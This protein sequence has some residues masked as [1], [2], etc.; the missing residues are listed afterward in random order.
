MSEAKLNIGQRINAVMKEIQY[1]KRDAT[2]GTGGSNSYMAVTHDAVTALIREALVTHGIHVNVQQTGGEL[3]TKRGDMLGDGTP[4]K[5]HLYL[6]K[7][8]IFFVNCD[9][10]ADW[11]CSAQQA[12]AMDSGDKM[13]GKA[14]SMATKYAMLKTFSIETGENEESRAYEAPDYTDEQKDLFDELLESGNALEFLVFSK[15]AGNDVMTALN[16]SFSKGSIVAGKKAV[17][18]LQ[19]AA[20]DML[21]DYAAQITVALDNHDNHALALTAELSGPEKKLLMPLL[22]EHQIIQ[23][24]KMKEAL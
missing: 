8:D 7:Y 20:W 24:T 16:S 11:V 14:E 5:Q 21:K 23:L 22:T 10:R 4:A 1:V 15:T 13:A 6:G 2:V 9:D 18:D 12:F 17:K 19:A 3:I